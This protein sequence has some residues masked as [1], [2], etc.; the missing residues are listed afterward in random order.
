MIFVRKI[1]TWGLL[2]SLVTLL[3]P[4]AEARYAITGVHTGIDA[5][6]GARPFR[7]NVLD[8]QKDIPSW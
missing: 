8:L 5:T 2:L 1:P 6:T 3:Q 4:F 7:L